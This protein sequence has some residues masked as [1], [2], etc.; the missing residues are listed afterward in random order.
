MSKKHKEQVQRQFTRT[1]EAFTEFAVRDTAEVTAEKV[2]FAKPQPDSIALDVACGPGAFVLALAPRVR[3]ACGVDLTAELLRRARALQNDKGIAN[4]FFS[5]GEAEQ[6]PFLDA[7]FDLVSCQMAFH[8]MPKPELVLREMAR[9]MKPEARLL[10]IDPLG[11]ES[12][13]K[14]ELHNR[15]EILRD[16]S[17]TSNLRLTT[18]LSLFDK[19]QLEIV[20]QAVKRRRRSFNHWMLRAGLA[21]KDRRYQEARKLLEESV[22]GDRGGYAPVVEGDDI[23]IIHNEG[24]FLLTRRADA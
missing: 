2:Q 3:F 20:S 10:V 18:F 24:M 15:I 6:L 7:S 1:A 19:L 23:Q 5:R 9:V 13:A 12:D 16:P 11:P 4:A 14:F 8:H 21:P 17:H 22:T